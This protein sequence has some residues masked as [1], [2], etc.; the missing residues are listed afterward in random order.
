MTTRSYRPEQ[1]INKI[2]EVEVLLGQGSSA[3]KTIRKI[4]VVEQTHCADGRN[5]VG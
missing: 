2:R 1:I 5:M 4:G 3:G